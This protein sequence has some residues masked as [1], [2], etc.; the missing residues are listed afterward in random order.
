MKRSENVSHGVTM[1]HA[2]E[3]R[4]VANQS[5]HTY[6]DERSHCTRCGKTLKRHKYVSTSRDNGESIAFC[7]KCFYRGKRRKYAAI[8]TRGGALIDKGKRPIEYD[9]R[10][11]YECKGIGDPLH[12][13]NHQERRQQVVE[14][15]DG[16]SFD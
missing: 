2:T 4:S 16:F 1:P 14:V 11:R 8:G 9:D 3:S 13:S 7:G 5:N 6:S 15:P 10:L 12:D